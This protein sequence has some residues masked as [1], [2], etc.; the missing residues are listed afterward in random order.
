MEN[1]I[2]RYGCKVP[3]SDTDASGWV[4]FSK[5]LVYAER[6]EHDFLSKRGIAVFDR[7]KGGWPRVKVSCQYKRPLT[8]QDKFEV[9]LALDHI[10]SSSLCWK[11]EIILESGEIAAIGEM[12]TVKVD[13]SG[14]VACLSE[15]EKNLLEAA[16]E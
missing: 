4:H 6:A 12:V 2:H 14:A 5:T 10:G 3:F 13:D 7:S 8:F 9:L 16:H 15:A 11:F 1:T